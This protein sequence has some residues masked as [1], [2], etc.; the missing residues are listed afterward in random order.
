MNYV[1]EVSI[2]VKKEKWQEWRDWMIEVHIP[3]VMNTGVFL[4]CELA[5]ITDPLQEEVMQFRITYLASSPEAIANYRSTL[6]PA[7]QVHHNE[8]F[9][10]YAKG[11]RRELF[12]EKVF[13]HTT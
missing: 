10:D 9:G 7:L 11:S 13:Q 3:D 12:I 1:Y 2:A 6:S 8:L 5:R 4:S